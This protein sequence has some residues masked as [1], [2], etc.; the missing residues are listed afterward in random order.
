[1]KLKQHLKT[2]SQIGVLL[3]IMVGIFASIIY[4][5]GLFIRIAIVGYII[6]VVGWVY[7]LIYESNE[8]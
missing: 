6:F 7:K 5:P 2:I 3:S 4:F 1:M 8:K